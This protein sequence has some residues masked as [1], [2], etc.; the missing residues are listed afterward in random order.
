MKDK[1][2]DDLAKISE[3]SHELKKLETEQIDKEF[4]Y[5]VLLRQIRLLDIELQT[6]RARIELKK[7]EIEYI[8]DRLCDDEHDE[9]R[10]YEEKLK[11]IVEKERAIEEA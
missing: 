2:L 5:D 6:D 1:T 8:D 9:R 10:E 4:N 11:A 3:I 7:K